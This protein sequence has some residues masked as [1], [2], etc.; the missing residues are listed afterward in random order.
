[1]PPK[2]KKRARP[3][4]AQ[5]GRARGKDN[6]LWQEITNNNM[7]STGVGA[8][9]VDAWE[10]GNDVVVLGVS[11][12]SQ[13][14]HAKFIAKQELNFHL[15]LDPE[16]E[17]LEMYGAWREKMNYGRT[18]LGISRSTFVIEA[19]GTLSYAKYGV[20]AKGHVERILNHLGLE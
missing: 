14:S 12:D 17:I 4:K 10:G 16:G 18:Y 19:D 13:K 3:S 15:L 8:E 7:Q 9:P 11:K 5:R 6:R 2:G 20:K 1:M